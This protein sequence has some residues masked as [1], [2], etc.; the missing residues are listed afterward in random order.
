MRFRSVQGNGLIALFFSQFFG[1]TYSAQC[2]I[3]IT[4][5]LSHFHSTLET[6]GVISIKNLTEHPSKVL[7]YQDSVFGIQHPVKIASEVWLEPFERRS[8]RYDWLSTDSSS[9]C[10]RV[11]IEPYLDSATAT[12]HPGHITLRISTRYAVDLYRGRI[13]DDLEIH[14]TPDGVRV[15]NRGGDFWAG[16]CYPMDGRIRGTPRLASG[17]LRPGDVRVWSVPT[18]A[19]GIWLERVDGH[20]VASPKP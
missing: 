13:A 18:D 20:V 7:I 10:R 17:V 2:Q 14:W 19:D 6:T 4:N 5:G 1:L 16:A 3:S 15:H 12:N 9:Q 8:V 11:Y